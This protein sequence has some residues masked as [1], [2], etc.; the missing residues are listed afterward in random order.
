MYVLGKFFVQ[1]FALLLHSFVH[2]VANLRSL[3]N[4]T[5]NQGETSAKFSESEEK[6]RAKCTRDATAT[7]ARSLLSRP[8]SVLCPSS[9]LKNCT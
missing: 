7:C 8:K 9:C 5:P 2:L 4:H 3:H 6:F 1:S